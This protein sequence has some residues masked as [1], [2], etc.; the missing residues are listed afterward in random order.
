MRLREWRP[1]PGE[2]VVVRVTRPEGVEGPTLTLD[3][4]QLA[5]SPGLRATRASLELRL[6]SSLGGQ[7]AIQLPEGAVLERVTIDGSE[8]PIRQEGREVML[9]LTPG[10]RTLGV[11]WQEPRG[12][13]T[14][15]VSPEVDLRVP[16]VN[17]DVTLSLPADRWLLWA[18]G[19]RLGPSV[20]F[21]PLLAVLAARGRAA[22]PDS[23]HPAAQLALAAAGTRPHA[24]AARRGRRRRR[25][26]ARA[27]LARR[28]RHG[29]ARALVR[30]RAGDARALDARGARRAPLLD[31]AGAARASGDA[32]RRPR[33]DRA[34]AA[35]V[36][37][38]GGSDA[39][40]GRGCSR[41]RCSPTAP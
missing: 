8:Q 35:L 41:S 17:A 4:S 38:P 22:R 23:Q 7:H 29:G 5:V 37:G 19:P 26:A 10:T 2:R 27:R 30:S 14:R 31:P 24:G 3:G 16:S 28:A 36:P 21:W 11:A 32:G 39:S 15:F 12:I 20:L 13:A 1:W 34:R 18:S 6:R 33:L 25:L 40:P 9:P